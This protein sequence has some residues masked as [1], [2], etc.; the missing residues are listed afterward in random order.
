[1]MN[2]KAMYALSYGLFVLT[3]RQGD[4]D[5]GCIINT[6]MQVTEKPNRVVAAVNKSG[7]THELILSAGAF[8]VSVI[9]EDAGFDL[10]QRF[11]FQS[12]RDV[13]KFSGFQDSVR[14]GGNG[15]LY[16][17]RGVNAWLACRVVS[18]TDLGSHTLFLADVTDGGVISAVPSATYAYYHAHIKPKPA[19]RPA[20][21]KGKT[22]WVC[23]VCGYIY[24]GETLPEDYICPICKHPA[25]DFERLE[26]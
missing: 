23:K 8:D 25:S 11:G 17:T 10:F 14:R 20:S 19:A 12:S 13:D 9:A 18:T 5:G 22:R 21:G 1:M 4:R 2:E 26:E 7:C 3:S 24:E 16:V 15:L 6:V